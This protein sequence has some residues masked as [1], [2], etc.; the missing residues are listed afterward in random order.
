M[1]RVLAVLRKWFDV[2]KEQV[3]FI[4][5]ALTRLPDNPTLL[6]AV[7]PPPEA[8]PRFYPVLFPEVTEPLDADAY[9]AIVRKL[10]D[11]NAQMDENIKAMEQMF[12]SQEGPDKELFKDMFDNWARHQK[13]LIKHCNEMLQ[14]HILCQKLPAEKNEKTGLKVDVQWLA[15]KCLVG[16]SGFQKT[17]HRKACVMKIH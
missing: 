16:F 6:Y 5:E 7:A 14:H 11:W 3:K 4:E 9:V 13:K 8:L 1:V 2:A 17:F 15:E 10:S 12:Q